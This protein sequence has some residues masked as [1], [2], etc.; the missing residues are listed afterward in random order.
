[1]GNKIRTNVTGRKACGEQ[2]G[3]DRINPEK[4]SPEGFR[5]GTVT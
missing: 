1:M 5:E 3:F 4:K 2:T